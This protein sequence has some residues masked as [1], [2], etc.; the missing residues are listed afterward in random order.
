MSAE[1]IINSNFYETRVALVENGQV[2][3]LYV[4]RASDRGISGNIYKGRVMRVLPGMQ[5]AFV[6]IGLEKAAFLYVS[7]V[8]APMEE[9]DQVLAGACETGVAVEAE[10]APV[11]PEVIADI[12]EETLDVEVSDELRAQSGY[13]DTPIEDRL[14]EGQEILVQVAKEPIGSKGARITTHTTLPG[15]H[16]V[17]MPLMNHVG[18]SRRIENEKERKRLREVVCAIKPPNCGLI[19]RTASDG[20][21]AEKLKA[22]MDFLLKLWENID[23]RSENAPVPSLIYQELDITLRAVRDLFTKEVDRLIIDSESEHRKVLNFAE[24]FMPSL[25]NAVEL[26]EGEEPIFDAYGIEMEVQRALSKKVWLKSG[27]YIVIEATEALTAID[28]NTG[29]YVGKRNLE[30]TILK[31]NLEAV[32]E[33]AFQLRLRNIGGIIIIDFI[34]MEKE[35]N[36]EK[37]FNALR[38]AMRKDKSKTNILRMSE[39]GLIEMTRKRTKESIGRVLCEPCYY[40]DGEGSLKSKQTICYDILRD[41][42]RERREYFG[43]NIMVIA[44]PDVADRFCDEERGALERVEERLHARIMVKGEPGFHLEQYEIAPTE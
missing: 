7:D 22:E 32:K 27:G 23:H 37:V 38:D 29:R 19:V 28:V 20:E 16:L 14:Q 18:V 43:R 44:H 5:A 40:C 9:L 30:E 12:S 15:R 31:T 39:L 8:R 24:T 42:E 26:Y 10:D 33:I 1:L 3:E 6:D 2:A 36:R 25:R 21:E 34:D 35:G 41:L 4:E 11:L 13:D 17:L